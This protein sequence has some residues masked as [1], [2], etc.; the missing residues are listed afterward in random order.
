MP[1]L[2]EKRNVDKK[3]VHVF[4][5][6]K[7]RGR[8]RKKKDLEQSKWGASSRFKCLFDLTPTHF[9]VYEIVDDFYIHLYTFCTRKLLSSN[10][11]VDN[12]SLYAHT[13]TTKQ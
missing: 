8:E 7:K 4:E 13:C 1:E 5:R 10:L 2:K 12:D 9:F 3:K 11:P 6:E